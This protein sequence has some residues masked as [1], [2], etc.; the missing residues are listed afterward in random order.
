MAER[1]P[2]A[3]LP[4]RQLIGLVDH[5]KEVVFETD[6]QGCWTYLNRSWTELTGFSVADSLGRPFLDF[7][8]ADDRGDHRPTLSA[9]RRAARR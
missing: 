6:R 1:V 3:A 2:R 8:F 7:V 9:G 4:A 5:L